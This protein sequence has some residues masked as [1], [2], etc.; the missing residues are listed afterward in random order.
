[1]RVPASAPRHASALGAGG[2]GPCFRARVGHH[3][4]AQGCVARGEGVQ[5]HGLAGAPRVRGEQR[6]DVAL[7]GH[8]AAHV[9]V[10]PGRALVGAQSLAVVGAAQEQ[11]EGLG[12]AAV[13]TGSAADGEGGKGLAVDGAV[14]DRIRLSYWWMNTDLPPMK[15]SV[16][17]V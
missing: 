7:A 5:G 8:Q 2:P 6:E 4:M 14:V 12:Q 10:G 17:W 11:V 13:K 16:S 9:E 3:H 15:I 1:M